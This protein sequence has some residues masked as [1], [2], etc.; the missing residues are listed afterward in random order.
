MEEERKVI[1]IKKNPTFYLFRARTFCEDEQDFKKSLKYLRMTDQMELSEESKSLA[2][3]IRSGAYC[4]LRMIPMGIF[5]GYKVL[6]RTDGPLADTIYPML[7]RAYFMLDEYDVARFYANVYLNQHKNSPQAQYFKEMF[8]EIDRIQKEKPSL[9]L[10]NDEYLLKRNLLI[11]H[12]NMSQGNLEEAI[13][14]YENMANY[15]NDDIRNELV[16]AYFFAG[17]LDR[18]SEIIRTYGKDS[19]QDLISQMLIEY[20][21]GHDENCEKIKKRLQSIEN[22]DLEQKYRIGASFSQVGENEL[23]VKYMQGYV[24]SGMAE[25]ELDFLYCITCINCGKGEQIKNRLL[26]LKLID[27]F[28]GYIF[29]YYLKFCNDNKKHS[30]KYIFNIP[31]REENI[32][33]AKV[34]ELLVQ[35]PEMLLNEFKENEDLFYYIAKQNSNI[36]SLLLLKLASIDDNCLDDFFDFILLGRQTKT[37]LKNRIA[38]KRA[39]LNCTR[40]VCIVRDDIFSKIILPN[41]LATKTNNINLYNA[42]MLL[43]QYIFTDI[44]NFQL[45]IAKPVVRLERKIKSD[46]VD[47]KI[48]A[49][50]LAWDILKVTRHAPLSKICSK[51]KVTQEE[52]YDFT[53]KYNLEV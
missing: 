6:K 21:M 16:M 7:A 36:S 27:P 18:A 53:T 2:D 9:Q 50:Y 38:L 34:K 20:S 30:F 49:T 26:D 25:P 29:D 14:T 19:V 43:V 39:G 3:S 12:E 4:G 13:K 22:V 40:R 42:V 32:V 28:D 24:E 46:N 10:V 52:F 15:Q 5:Y 33:N 23:A 44:A 45:T 51:F 48:L 41:N 11:A 37:S 31:K 8:A 17:E 35:T 47:E 1:N